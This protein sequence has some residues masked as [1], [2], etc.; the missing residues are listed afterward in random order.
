MP[1]SDSRLVDTAEQKKYKA[2]LAELVK[3]GD[4]RE[5][6]E[7]SSKHPRWTSINLGVY[8][9]IRCS[10]IHRNIGVHVTKVRSVTLDSWTPELVNFM[11]NM[12]NAK[13]NWFW[14]ARLPAGAKPKE[15]DTVYAVEAF[16]RDKYERKRFVRQGG[17]VI[18]GYAHF[19]GSRLDTIDISNPNAQP[20]KSESD[21]EEERAKEKERSRRRRERSKQA[22]S[23]ELAAA[24]VTTRDLNAQFGG[25]SLQSEGKSVPTAQA[26][27][28][29]PASATSQQSSDFDLFSDFQS[30]A[31]SPSAVAAATAVAASTPTPSGGDFAA[32]F[33]DKPNSS[34]PSGQPPTHPAR[35]PTGDIMAL[36]DAPKQQ[37]QPA[38]FGAGAYVAPSVG[39]YPQMGGMVG[40]MYGYP[41]SQPMGYGMGGYAVPAGAYPSTNMSYP[42]PA[43]SD[44]LDMFAGVGM[45]AARSTPAAAAPK[46]AAANGSALN[47]LD[48]FNFF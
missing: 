40:M 14:E 27:H 5:C 1:P 12:G 8:V 31:S 32:F 11:T 47:A 4:N 22:E 23:K 21:S 38:I 34:L 18:D 15:S 7:C 39:M 6:A 44:P 19:N 25:L 48:A 17:S 26:P 35:R 33:S 2:A 28:P 37:P 10:G 13:A 42:Q 3:I 24:A 29:S 16:I 30:A 9:C 46:P 36:F 20:R 41:A 45:G 43:C